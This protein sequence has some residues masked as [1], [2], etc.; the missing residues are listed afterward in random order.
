MYQSQLDVVVFS[1]FILTY[2]NHVKKWAHRISTND[3]ITL[4][5][6]LENLSAAIVELKILMSLHMKRQL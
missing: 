4:N 6:T 5:E 3:I 2:K 1:I